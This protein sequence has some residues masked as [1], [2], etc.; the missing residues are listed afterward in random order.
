MS[1]A[2][3]A[4]MTLHLPPAILKTAQDNN[5]SLFK[6]LL[7]LYNELES[8]DIIS[9]TV[10]NIRQMVA[11]YLNEHADTY[12]PFVASPIVSDSPY[13]HDTTAPD[14]IDAYIS[15]IPDPNTSSIL[16]WERYLERLRSGSWG[17]HVVIAALANMF[18]VTINVIHARPQACSAASTSPNDSQATSEVNLGLLLQYHF[19]GLDKQ[20]QVAT[21]TVHSS[22][23]QTNA[24]NQPI[25]TNNQPINT[26]NQPINTNNQPIN[27]NNQPINTNNQPINTNNQPT[28]EPTC[29]L[30]DATIEEGDEHTKQITGGPLARMMSIES[31]EALGDVHCPS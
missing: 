7:V 25:N 6:M 27:T 3:A 4:Q 1:I 31:P 30:E 2:I 15:T 21:S 23:Q 5:F 26:N 8:S 22:N 24:N 11:T 17:D 14:A 28:N 16:A 19:V 13:N 9:T 18:N 12:M 10:E 20:V 29:S